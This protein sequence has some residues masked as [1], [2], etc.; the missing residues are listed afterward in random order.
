MWRLILISLPP[1]FLW[2][3]LAV[4]LAGYL[5]AHFRLPESGQGADIELWLTWWTCAAA[6]AAL[7][8]LAWSLAHLLHLHF[9]VIRRRAKILTL[10]AVF[11]LGLAAC[12]SL[13]AWGACAWWAADFLRGNPPPPVGTGAAARIF[14][15]LLILPLLVRGLRQNRRLRRQN[16]AADTL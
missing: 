14:C 7:P 6:A 9:A 1:V 11:A 10:P 16:P 8:V 15:Q 5:Q 2:A 12:F 4:V 13:P 3:D